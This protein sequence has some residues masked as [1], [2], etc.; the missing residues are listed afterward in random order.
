MPKK[1]QININD[2][3]GYLTVIEIL[4]KSHYLCQCVCGEKLIRK[5]HCLRNQSSCGCQRRYKI[6]RGDKYHHLT[7]I[8]YVENNKKM[9]EFLCDCGT[10]KYTL[11][12]NVVRKNRPV[13]SCGCLQKILRKIQVGQKYG[14][15]TVIDIIE[16]NEIQQCGVKYKIKC[17]CE[18][19]NITYPRCSGLTTGTTQSCGCKNRDIVRVLGKQKTGSNNPMW[20]N[21]TQ[22]QKRDCRYRLRGYQFRQYILK[23]YDKCIKCGSKNDLVAHHLDGYN[24]CIELRDDPENNGVCLCGNCHRAFHSKYGKRDNTR[25]QFQEYMEGK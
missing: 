7:F 16:T 8:K 2:T 21:L 13:K 20:K 3:F 14:R 10:T 23:K 24:W 25:E 9:G 22:Q 17:H 18:C 4:E 6:Q 15:L 1:K 12:K 19:G 11:I 5:T